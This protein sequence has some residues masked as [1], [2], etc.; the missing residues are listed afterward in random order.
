[1]IS[2]EAYR[3]QIGCFNQAKVNIRAYLSSDYSSK[4]S[5]STLSFSVSLKSIITII[6]IYVIIC[7]LLL[8]GNVELNPGPIDRIV[9]ASH[10]QGNSRYGYTAGT[11]CLC[12][13][14]FALIVSVL[15]EPWYSNL[16][17]RVLFSLS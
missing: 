12:N 16:V 15:K 13:S 6:S 7:M 2:I 17:P 5:C 1:M 14:L 8:S 11:Q 3:A 4:K 10:D 9:K